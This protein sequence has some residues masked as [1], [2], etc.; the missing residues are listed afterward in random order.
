MKF[1]HPFYFLR[2]GETQWNKDRMTQGQ[3]DSQLNSRGILQAERA[4][5]ILRNEPIDRIVSSPLS[6]ARHTAE[7][8]AQH[9][10]VEIRFD[11]ELMECNLG[12]HQG[13]PHGTWLPEYWT[14]RYDPPNGETYSVFCQRVWQ[15]MQRAVALGPNTLIVAHGGL[16]IAAHEYVSLF[17]AL[18]PMPNALPVQVT[19]QEES[20]HCEILEKD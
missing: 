1:E 20:W 14:G 12:D 19:P 15:A 16:W 13:N 18:R 10:D 11:D 9:H 4:A 8:V 2:H 5:D 17:P 7:A 3:M 6:R